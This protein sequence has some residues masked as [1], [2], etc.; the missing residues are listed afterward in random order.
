MTAATTIARQAPP[1]DPHLAAI[2]GEEWQTSERYRLVFRCPSR[3]KGKP[4]YLLTC[5]EDGTK[6]WCSC[7]G[8]TFHGHCTH[9]DQAGE[10]ARL[11][12]VNLYDG[13]GERQLRAEEAQLRALLG[14]A[15]GTSI[16]YTALAAEMEKRQRM[17]NP[18][19]LNERG[20]KAKL[21][22][23]GDVA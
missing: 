23:F 3:R 18:A 6:A 13:W 9:A 21:D 19:L 17:Q 2:E 5:E 11:A 10:I 15:L 4:G 22:L 16:R 8:Y 14:P 7:D 1:F 12:H 20:R